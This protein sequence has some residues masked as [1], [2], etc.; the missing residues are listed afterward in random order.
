VADAAAPARSS[1]LTLAWLLM[2]LSGFAGLALQIA[3]TYQFGI[4]LGHEA[5]AVLAV[6]AG[7]F[8]GLALG[9]FALGP[10]ILRSRRPGRWYAGLEAAIGLWALLLALAMPYAG[11][12]LTMLIGAQPAPVRH[13]S[14]AFL[15]AF[16]LMLPASAA[17]GATVPA[18]QR[19]LDRLAHQGYALGG[20][21]A[22]NTAGAMA[23]ALAA[24]FVLAPA[25]GYTATTAAAALLNLACAAIAWTR[26]GAEDRAPSS[27]RASAP[28]RATLL[29]LLAATGLLGIGYE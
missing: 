3:W 23:G 7:F 17:M 19:V 27:P 2:A 18:M 24:A 4:W 21:Y 25:L 6:I 13:W 29:W 15:G 14:I 20:L 16:L 9:A 1:S 12:W 8:G 11:G 22:A 26:F 10:R 5:V 28:R